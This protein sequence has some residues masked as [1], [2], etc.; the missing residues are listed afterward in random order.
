MIERIVLVKS[1]MTIVQTKRE[2][3]WLSTYQVVMIPSQP[4][5]SGK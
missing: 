2:S 1:A 3:S 4:E 5:K